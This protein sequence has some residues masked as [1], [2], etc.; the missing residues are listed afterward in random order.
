MSNEQDEGAAGPAIHPEEPILGDN[1]SSEV[2]HIGAISNLTNILGELLSDATARVVPV[3]ASKKHHSGSKKPS[4]ERPQSQTN[5]AASSPSQSKQPQKSNL[6]VKLRPGNNLTVSQDYLKYLYNKPEP[7][8]KSSKKSSGEKSVNKERKEEKQKKT[9]KVKALKAQSSEDSASDSV[10]SN[11]KDSKSKKTSKPSKR[12]KTDEPI[13]LKEMLGESFIESELPGNIDDDAPPLMTSVPSGLLNGAEVPNRNQSSWGFRSAKPFSEGKTQPAKYKIDDELSLEDTMVVRSGQNFLAQASTPTFKNGN[14]SNSDSK[15]VL[16]SHLHSEIDQEEQDEDD[17]IDEELEEQDPHESSSKEEETKQGQ[18]VNEGTEDGN[19]ISFDNKE[20]AKSDSESSE[21]EGKVAGRARTNEKRV[22]K[23]EKKGKKKG[24]KFKSDQ[25]KIDDAIAEARLC[26]GQLK[27]IIVQ[28]PIQFPEKKLADLEIAMRNIKC[29]ISDLLE[30]QETTK[31]KDEASELIAKAVIGISS[32]KW[33]SKIVRWVTENSYSSEMIKAVKDKLGTFARPTKDEL[34]RLQ[35]QQEEEHMIGVLEVDRDVQTA[36]SLSIERTQS[37]VT[38]T[39][40]ESA[41]ERLQRLRKELKKIPQAPNSLFTNKPEPFATVPAL[42]PMPP[43]SLI[44]NSVLSENLPKPK[45]TS[46]SK[47]SAKE[48]PSRK[49]KHNIEIPP[50]APTLNP[51]QSSDLIPRSRSRSRSPG[52]PQSPE[53]PLAPHPSSTFDN[54]NIRNADTT[55]QVV[56]SQDSSTHPPPQP[57]LLQ[58]TSIN[59][60]TKSIES[61]RYENQQPSSDQLELHHPLNS[62]THSDPN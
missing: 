43:S 35:R 23:L 13:D 6:K 26:G 24:R 8:P 2:H 27:T 29:V 47:S 17:K 4:A 44:I 46:A 18:E 53:A 1:S 51:H 49:Q 61:L 30:K 36:T 9:A 60:H 10:E 22:A 50:P 52:R 39:L 41:S 56:P 48:K 55:P 12:F 42:L 54:L 14:S 32:P 5:P 11:S 25:Q 62:P 34:R 3:S 20:D 7:K 58:L 16:N 57:N 28:H 15:N 21:G 45:S 31:V 59:T 37:E 19:E 38:H 40:S 33:N